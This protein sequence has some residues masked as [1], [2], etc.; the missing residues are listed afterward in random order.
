VDRYRILRLVG[1]GGMG[2]VYAAHD[3]SLH[4]TIALKVIRPHLAGS[5]AFQARLLRESNAMARVSH[6]NVAVVYDVG[7]SDGLLFIAMEWVDGKTLGQWLERGPHSWRA[8]VEVFVQAAE[9]LA[10]AHRA[11]LVHRDFKPDNVLV[12]DSLRVRVT[13]FGLV[14]WSDS[15]TSLTDSTST[16]P[17][18]GSS[19]PVPAPLTDPGVTMGTPAYMAPEQ[20]L[21]KPADARSDQFSFFVALYEGLYGKLPFEGKNRGGSRRG[22][23]CGRRAPSVA[24]LGTTTSPSSDPA[25]FVQVADPTIRLDGCRAASVASNESHPVRRSPDRRYH[26]VRDALV[27]RHRPHRRT[28]RPRSTTTRRSVGL[29]TSRQGH[30]RASDIFRGWVWGGCRAAARRVLRIMAGSSSRAL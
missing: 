14:R 15:D 29:G 19:D 27:D 24:T 16:H 22:N 26:L 11:G 9:G 6:P 17:A 21:G 5:T 7:R 23:R 13:D 8:I 2:M 28:M 18:L 20:Y 1:F 30:E 4:R 25:R 12:D 10:A 3:P